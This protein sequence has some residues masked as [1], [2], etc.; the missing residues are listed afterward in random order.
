MYSMDRL[1]VD[2]QTNKDAYS[3]MTSN[4]STVLSGDERF[5]ST[6]WQQQ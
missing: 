3:I 6:F 1:K 2:D 5:K 4:S